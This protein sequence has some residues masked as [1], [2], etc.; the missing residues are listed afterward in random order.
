MLHWCSKRR[1]FLSGP[2]TATLLC[3][4]EGWQ[5]RCSTGSK[6]FP[7]YF[8]FAWP[9]CVCPIL[10]FLTFLEIKHDYPLELQQPCWRQIE[11]KYAKTLALSFC[12]P[13]IE[14]LCPSVLNSHEKSPK[15]NLISPAYPTTLQRLVTQGFCNLGNPSRFL[16]LISSH[17]PFS[18]LFSHLLHHICITESHNVIL[19]HYVK[20]KV[21]QKKYINNSFCSCQ[22]HAP[23]ILI[24]R[25]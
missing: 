12:K 1:K 24:Q 13:R 3:L 10:T 9:L 15:Q 16:Y 4:G 22:T 7:S 20:S 2:Q 25:K 6:T 19:G 8:L 14:H 21:K 17:K 23:L 11:L 5:V 18:K